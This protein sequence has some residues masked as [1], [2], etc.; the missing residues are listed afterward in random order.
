MIAECPVCTGGIRTQRAESM[1]YVALS[2]SVVKVLHLLPGD[3][4][5]SDC[6]HQ[7]MEAQVLLCTEL[8]MTSVK[9]VSGARPEYPDQIL[10]QGAIQGLAFDAG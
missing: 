7:P 10:G 9:N 1:L 6:I 4:S 2:P 3:T 8:E 5:C